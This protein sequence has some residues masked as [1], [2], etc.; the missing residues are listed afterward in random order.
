MIR[1]PGQRRRTTLLALG[2]VSTIVLG[3]RSATA[4]CVGDCTGDGIV[5][6][7][8]RIAAANVTLGD[9]SVTNRPSFDANGNGQVTIDELI[10]LADN[11]LDRK[12]GVT[13]PAG[14][15]TIGVLNRRGG[16][17]ATTVVVTGKV[18]TS[19]CPA[20]SATDTDY[21]RSLTI[22][23]ACSRSCT[24]GTGNSCTCDPGGIPR[25]AYTVTNLSPG[26]WLHRVE[27]SATAQKQ[28]R[29]ALVM[30]DPATPATV[31]WTAYKS[32]LTVT[33]ELDDGSAG[34]LRH[35]ITT[36][37]GESGNPP[38]LIQF[39]H[40]L[41]ANG[42]ITVRLTDPTPLRVSK[43]TIVDGTD[44]DGHPSPV[45][46]FASRSYRTI[47]ELDPTNKAVANAATIR[48][49]SAGSGL[50]G[51]Y[52]RRVLG[53]DTLLPRSDQDLVA[54]GAGA[55]RGFV[56][57]CKLDGGS[58]HRVMQDCPA[59]TPTT[60]TNPAQGKDCIDV[61]HTGSLAFADAIV[62]SESELRHCYDRPVKS[63]NAA[64]IVRDSWIHNNSRGGLFAQSRDGKLQALRNLIEENGKNCPLATRCQGGPRDGMSCCPWGLQGTACVTAPVLP[65]DCPGS[66]DPGCGSGTCLP[67]DTVADVS[68]AACGVSGTRR[69]AAQLSAESGGGTDLRTQSNV[70]RNG[71]RSGVF[72][73][74]DSTGSMQGDFIC[75]MQFGVET[76]T[77]A[78]RGGQIVVGGIASVLNRNAGVLLNQSGATVADINFGDGAANRRTGMRNAFSNNGGPSPT[79]PTNFNM[80]SRGPTRK[81]ERNQWQHGGDGKTCRAAAVTAN[82]V[83]FAN[84]KLDVDPCEAHR[85][86]NG[87]TTLVNVF[88]KA[89]R[90]GEIVHIV[91]TG[92]NAIEGYGGNAG[93]ATSCAALAVGNTCGTIPRGTC[94][95]F[96]GLDGGWNAA[97]AILAVTPTHLVVKSP[98]DCGAPRRVRVRRKLADGRGGT[99]T[100]STA[101]FCRNE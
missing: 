47:I 13:C 46:P 38:A 6:I 50:R 96:E 59:N 81:A 29:R 30:G 66:G 31:K 64:T 37:S 56:E 58:A 76:T 35:A 84:A 48:F 43:E 21:T 79:A 52:L 62:V 61:E 92:F 63:Q 42:L 68:H 71:M 78:A 85:K 99:F 44:A 24:C 60:A 22:P 33:S 89:A 94:V 57:A 53:A 40:G 39:N 10:R 54:F 11:S 28:S 101:F 15:V 23:A 8:E 100:S 51:V 98:I 32:V 5:A 34:T 27:V 97:T 82:D 70:V 95:E 41:F 2:M 17:T 14:R 26:E 20:D 4:Q 45:W 73:R 72:Y 74:N 67:L 19:T 75:G 87:G 16:A 3:P 80:G 88:P 1:V 65:T 93:G 55:T 77:G 18:L 25:C 86:P 83:A 36:A 49:N 12:T 7:N 69:A 9:P 91:G 90:S